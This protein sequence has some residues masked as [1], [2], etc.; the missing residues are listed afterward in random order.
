MEAGDLSIG[1]RD[2]KSTV[3]HGQS[4]EDGRRVEF[5]FGDDLAVRGGK[6]EECSFRS[7][8]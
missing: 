3:C 2:E 8:G 6:H 7:V 1:G 4:I 5:M